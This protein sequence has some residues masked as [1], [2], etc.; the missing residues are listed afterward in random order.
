[1]LKLNEISLNESALLEEL[2]ATQME[3]FVMNE[4]EE[5]SKQKSEDGF[6]K[7]LKDFFIN[8]AKK[9]KEVF[10][11]FMNFFTSA[12]N[13]LMGRIKD[14]EKYALETKARFKNSLKTPHEM[15]DLDAS[16]YGKALDRA[17]SA[18]SSLKD[19]SSF[20]SK[21]KEANE[22]LVDATKKEQETVKLSSANDAVNAV[23]LAKGNIDYA[24]KAA[25]EVKG[26]AK[27]VEINSKAGI[28]ATGKKDKSL[29]TAHREL[30]KRSSKLNS[31]TRRIAS[32][33][34]KAS[35]AQLVGAYVTCKKIRSEAKQYER[36]FKKAVR[37]SDQKIDKL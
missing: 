18:V 23:K 15:A 33:V 20:E 37:K 7:K 12:F 22:A 11:K 25:A 26:S 34:I 5:V 6:W 36:G 14:V 29:A 1:M 31:T 24:K 21:I 27:E 4:A 16:N 32:G 10:S 2:D 17:K 30:C 13:K 8:I 28:T 35:N 9:I 19:A 3:L